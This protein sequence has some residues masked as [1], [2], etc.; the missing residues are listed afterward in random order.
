M[1]DDSQVQDFLS[2]SDNDLTKA[3]QDAVV[4]QLTGRTEHVPMA[5]THD[6]GIAELQNAQEELR[7]E[8][9]DVLMNRGYRRRDGRV[10]EDTSGS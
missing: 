2:H 5:K 4:A 8:L 3:Q 9:W 1:S 6:A 10:E 7:K